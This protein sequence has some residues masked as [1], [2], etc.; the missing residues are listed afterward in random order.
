MWFLEVQ[1]A[2]PL[3]LTC[4]LATTALNICYSH[5]LIFQHIHCNLLL[6]F[7]FYL[8]F[9]LNVFLYTSLE[10]IAQVLDFMN[11]IIQK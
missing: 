11:K 8:S 3:E 1:G 9:L 6:K 10:P 2:Q 5:I 7:L 4:Q